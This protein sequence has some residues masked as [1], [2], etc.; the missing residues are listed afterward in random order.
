MAYVCSRNKSRLRFEIDDLKRVLQRSSRVWICFL[1]FTMFIGGQVSAETAGTSTDYG[2]VYDKTGRLEFGILPSGRTVNYQYDLSGN[3]LKKTFTPLANSESPQ[4]TLNN[5]NGEEAAPA[6][7]YSTRP[8]IT[9]TQT[10]DKNV[11]DAFHIKLYSLHSSKPVSDYYGRTSSGFWKLDKDLEAG[12]KYRVEVRVTD[13]EQWSNKSTGWFQV[14]KDSAEIPNTGFKGE[15]LSFDG[16][17]QLEFTDV[18]V[19]TDSGGKNTVE[20][21]MN[22]DGTENVM[23]FGWNGGYNLWFDNGYF[24]FNTGNADIYGIP[25]AQLKNKWVHV[26]AVFYNGVP[27]A[28]N[29]ELY[30][31][32]LKQN[33]SQVQGITASNVT[34]TSTVY[35]SGSGV[36]KSK[37]KF[38]GRIAD[39]HMWN[40]ALK[41]SEI[42]KNM[43]G[44]LNGNEPGLVGNWKLTDPA[45]TSLSF[46]GT[47]QLE[48]TNVAVN[49][50]DGAKNTV[51]FWMNWDGTENIIPFSWNGGY[52]LWFDNGHFGFNTGNADL[53]GISS[54]GLKNKWVHVAA[55]FYNGVPDATNSEL[56]INGVKQNISQVQSITSSSVTA[57]PT[58]YVSGYGVDKNY[59]FKGKIADVH[60]WNRALTGSQIQSNMYRTLNVNEPGLVGNWRVSDP[61][62]KASSFD[63]TKQLEYTNVAVNTASGA[64]NTVE[65]WM[66]WDG[67]ENV[68]PFGW[69]GSY[70]L[71]FNNGYFGFNTGNADIYGIPSAELK[72]K[73]V[74]VAAVFYNGVPDATNSELYING[75][76]QSISQVQNV[77]TA[78]V[79][80]TPTAYVSGFGVDKANYKFKGKLADVHVWNR[81]I[82][83]S[84]I[85][86]NIY[87][88]LMNNEP[89]LVGNWRL[90][91]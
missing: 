63:G 31:N 3:L 73:W 21:W 77:T 16:T 89:G 78:S 72:N 64:K 9:W 79:T 61:T 65:F 86:S 81:A 32:G 49:T 13:G 4:I 7:V 56:Y 90:A 53:Y 59:K 44:A 67:T 76:K 20:F 30:I 58:L 55:V 35:V 42:Q 50:A 47:R 18:A 29:S 22:W 62:L 41:G 82:T 84:E 60:V 34:A 45:L 27:N 85:Q 48:Y 14:Q 51:E 2:Y 19:N 39:V 33:I 88:S 46:D 15:S 24:G 17:K 5:P 10:D 54:A 8:T 23:P 37:Y 40:R 43:Y 25:S 74:H 87:R 28:A 11:F 38:T 12:Q 52:D 83:S 80:V 57:T 75:V 69:N 1:I 26:A 36:D 66:N 68:M 91:D 6:L 71:W 70:D